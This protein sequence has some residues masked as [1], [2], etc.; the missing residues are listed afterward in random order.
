[1]P[2]LLIQVTTRFDESPDDWGWGDGEALVYA[3]TYE[4]AELPPRELAT[5]SFEEAL[6]DVRKQFPFITDTRLT[7]ED[8]SLVIIVGLVILKTVIAAAANVAP[9][10][11]PS[12]LSIAEALASNVVWEGTKR[13]WNRM[14]SRGRAPHVLSDDPGSAK[15]VALIRGANELAQLVAA[16]RRCLVHF[17]RGAIDERSKRYQRTLEPAVTR[18]STASLYRYRSVAEG[19][20]PLRR[21]LLDLS[22][23]IVSCV[24]PAHHPARRQ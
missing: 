5:E 11:A 12:A 7:T 6:A 20:R 18:N 19:F 8:G 14:R 22:A 15:T 4:L 3:E 9:Y 24:R 16:D 1:M 21:N 2:F 10:V 17:V 23:P 13:L